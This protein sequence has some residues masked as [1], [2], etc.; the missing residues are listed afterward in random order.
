MSRFTQVKRG[1]YSPDEVDRYIATLEEVITGYKEKDNAIKNAIIS[2]QVAADNVVKN[3]RAQ[4][5]EYKTLITGEL[6]KVG[7]EV[8]RRRSQLRE[9]QDQYST[10]VRK[11]LTEVN[12]MEFSNLYAKLDDVT[13]LVNRLKE[14]D[15][16]PPPTPTE[17]G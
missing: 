7:A 14:S 6:D 8:E 2:A 15:L 11:H 13:A 17:E 3:A 4:A 10:L 16:M 12:D 1:G 9:L 5:E